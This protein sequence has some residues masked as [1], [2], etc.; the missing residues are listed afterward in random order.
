ML[1]RKIRIFYLLTKRA[2]LLLGNT[3]CEASVNGQRVLLFDG[4]ATVDDV[5]EALNERKSA[6]AHR[7]RFVDRR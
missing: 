4:R 2:G 3:R 1:V 5:F 6:A 7:A